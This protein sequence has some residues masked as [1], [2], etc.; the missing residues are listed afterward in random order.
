M[1]LSREKRNRLILNKPRGCGLQELLE[2]CGLT[3]LPY[4]NIAKC[5]RAS[6]EGLENVSDVPWSGHPPV[7]DE[8][9]E[10]VLTLG[11]EVLELH[12]S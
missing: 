9:L 8:D 12:D 2:S 6:R 5:I 7:S 11:G 4:R 3:A 10:T 1:S